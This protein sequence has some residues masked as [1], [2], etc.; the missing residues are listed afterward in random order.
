MVKSIE[1][2]LKVAKE[3]ELKTIFQPPNNF[4]QKDLLDLLE[5]FRQ[6][7]SIGKYVGRHDPG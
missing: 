5:E 2:V 3:N 7:R 1:S 4:I 6:K